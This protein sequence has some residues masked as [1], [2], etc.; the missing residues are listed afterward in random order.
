M[1]RE[2]GRWWSEVRGEGVSAVIYVCGSSGNGCRQVSLGFT[3]TA[4]IIP[5]YIHSL[6]EPEI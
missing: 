4:C 3:V 6:S 5:P 1:G 2:G